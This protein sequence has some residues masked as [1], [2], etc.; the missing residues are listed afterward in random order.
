[1]NKYLIFEKFKSG[2][3]SR[4]STETALVKVTNDLLLAADT[5]LYSILILLDLSSAFDTVDHNI[6][7][8]RLKNSVGIRDVALDWFVSYLSDWSFS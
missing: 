6:L 2:F 3:R 8:N 5:G 7:I 4:H 1:M